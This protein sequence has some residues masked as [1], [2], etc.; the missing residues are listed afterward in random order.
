M[1]QNHQCAQLRRSKEKNDPM[2]TPF[3]LIRSLLKFVL[4][5]SNTI[6]SWGRANAVLAPFIRYGLFTLQTI[7][8]LRNIDVEREFRLWYRSFTPI[9]RRNQ[10][11]WTLSTAIALSIDEYFDDSEQLNRWSLGLYPSPTHRRSL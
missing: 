2:G 1:S 5:A 6:Y 4:Q 10:Q 11:Q 9:D 7:N 8:Q 3:W